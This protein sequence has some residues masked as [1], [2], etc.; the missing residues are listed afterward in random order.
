MAMLVGQ[1]KE[2]QAHW[3]KLLVDNISST[4]VALYFN[5]HSFGVFEQ[6]FLL[7]LITLLIMLIV[8]LATHYTHYSLRMQMGERRTWWSAVGASHFTI[9]IL[10]PFTS[11]VRPFSFIDEWPFI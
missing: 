3:E 1:F 11:V 10:S 5:N 6:A 7:F 9:P 8:Y 2:K 4:C